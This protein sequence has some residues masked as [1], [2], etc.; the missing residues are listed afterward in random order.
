ME[1]AKEAGVY[2]DRRRSHV[3]YGRDPRDSNIRIA[4]SLPP[5]EELDQAMDVFVCCVKLAY[6]EKLLR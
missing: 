5:L 6:V 3:P 2:H 1:L 4:P